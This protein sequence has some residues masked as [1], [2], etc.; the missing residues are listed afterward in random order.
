MN[1]SLEKQFSAIRDLKR[2]LYIFDK[3]LWPCKSVFQTVDY[4]NK[5]GIK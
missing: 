4:C 1:T 3:R 5:W 2:T